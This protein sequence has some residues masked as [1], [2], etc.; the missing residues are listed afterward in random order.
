MRWQ[1]EGCEKQTRWWNDD[2]KSTV[3]QKKVMYKRLLDFGTEEA[4]K[5]YNEAKTEAKRVVR[6][7][8]NEEWVQLERELEKDVSG[9]PQ[10]FWARINGRSKDSMSCIH[11]ENGQVLVDEVE[12]IERWKEHF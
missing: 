8:K 5:K 3:R 4:K 12:V 11:N 9:N 7:A 10:R 2:V 6:R 1:R